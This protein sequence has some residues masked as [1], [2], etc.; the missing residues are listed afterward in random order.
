MQIP[1]ACMLRCASARGLDGFDAVTS[2][3]KKQDYRGP[4]ARVVTT[5]GDRAGEVGQGVEEHEIGRDQA[6]PAVENIGQP[7]GSGNHTPDARDV[8]NKDIRE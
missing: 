4:K 1:V 7:D 5:E 3:G 6:E 8:D 2:E